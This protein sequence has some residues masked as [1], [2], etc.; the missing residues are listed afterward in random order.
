MAVDAW[1]DTQCGVPE[2]TVSPEECSC[3]DSSKVDQ[4]LQYQIQGAVPYDK[5]AP[6]KCTAHLELSTNA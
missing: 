3:E 2:I 4:P 5:V 6:S 1:P